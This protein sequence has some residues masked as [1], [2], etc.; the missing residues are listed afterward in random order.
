MSDVTSNKKRN[1]W[2]LAFNII[3]Y[4]FALAGFGIIGAWAFYQLGFTKNGGAVDENYRYLMSVEEMENLQDST[5]SYEQIQ[6]KTIDQYAKLAAFGKFYPTNANLIMKAMQKCNDPMLADRMIAAA[7]LYAGNNEEY[8]QLSKEIDALLSKHSQQQNGNIIPWMNGVEWEALKEAIV[9]DSALINEAGRLTGVEPRLIAGC[10]IGEQ[11][12]LFNS[13]REMF[14][15]YLGPVKVLS[16]QSQFSYGVNGIKEFTAIAVENNLKDRNS[17][18]YMG[19]NYEHL[20]DFKTEN[21]S[22]E[23]YNRLVDY[24]NHLYSYL[25]TGCIIHQTMMQWK[26]A[27][28]DISNRPD[29]LFTLF[30]VGFSQSKPKAD[31]VCGGSHITVDGNIYTFGAIGF[32][33]YYSGELVDAFPYWSK[34]FISSEERDQLSADQIADIQNHMSNCAR[35]EKGLEYKQQDQPEQPTSGHI[36]T[37]DG[38]VYN[39]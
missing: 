32:D 33:F 35:P 30:N 26:R 13:K 38:F 18:Y 34:R 20:L 15:K 23:R 1:Y 17:E 19:P 37:D 21:H 16:V 22:T 8:S 2:K 28:H 27:G 6:A 29:I 9:K 12:R 39:L 10:L 25:Y 11:I 24:R 7:S 3:V 14:K 5:L 31:P 4:A 36:T